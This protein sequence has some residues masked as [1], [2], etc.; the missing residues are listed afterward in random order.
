VTHDTDGR[1]VLRLAVSTKVA[2]G[3]PPEGD[4]NYP[5]KLDH[6]VF[7]RKKKTAKGVDWELDPGLMKH[8]G[9]ACK[10]FEIMLI[11]DDIDNVFPT[12]YAWW[13]ATEWKCR[14]D[15]TLATR[16]T[17]GRPT[18]EPWTTCGSQ[19]PELA[20][21][22]CKPSGDLR[23]VLADFPRLGSV[24]RIHTSSY[25]SIRQI[26]SALEEIQTFTGSRL[27]GITA[28][29]AVRPEQISYFDR[30]E[31]RKKATTIWALSLEADGDDVG[32][33]VNKLTG[34]ARLFAETRKLLGWGDRTV[35]VVED[36]EQRAPEITAEFYPATASPAA[37]EESPDVNTAGA[38]AAPEDVREPRHEFSPPWA[39]NGTKAVGK[40][41]IM[42]PRRR[43]ELPQDEGKGVDSSKRTI[44]SVATPPQSAKAESHDPNAGNSAH[45]QVTKLR[46]IVG[47]LEPD[48]TGNQIR[49]TGKG[50][51]YVLFT[52]ASTGSKAKVYCKQAESLPEIA[53]RR[54]QEAVA[55]VEVVTNGAHPCYIL[56][57][58][59]E[60]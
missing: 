54:G 37:T 59:V 36:E 34:N 7:L 32:N 35:E 49:R 47:P 21:G 14:G 30:K 29:L 18:G 28:R 56:K 44:G 25:R 9:N 3:M 60:G 45:L 51:E 33:L 58:F 31:H 50:I 27:A 13:T 15:G 38:Q 5:S 16:R 19:C 4:R 17:P 11:D 39:D 23:F 53:R 52:M 1:A 57:G 55:Q 26:H 8:Y 20:S 41:P 12:S 2:I 42:E 48:V 40:P 24:C 6:F 22:L 43:T 10:A 46:G